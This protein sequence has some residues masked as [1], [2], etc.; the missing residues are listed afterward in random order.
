MPEWRYILKRTVAH[1]HAARIALANQIKNMIR[2]MRRTIELPVMKIETQPGHEFYIGLA[3]NDERCGNTS[4]PDYV[5]DLFVQIGRPLSAADI[6]TWPTPASEVD[7][8]LG[9]S[10]KWDSMTSPLDFEPSQPITFPT[11]L[12]D[13]E[14]IGSDESCENYDRLH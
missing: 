10:F 11:S 14:G 1:G 4:P 2:V 12:N 7:G 5:I 8:F 9:G 6:A 3:V 13:V